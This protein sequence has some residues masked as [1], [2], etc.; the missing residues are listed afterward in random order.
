[1]AGLEGCD[2]PY[3]TARTENT[4]NW[5]S[6]ATGF[7]PPPDTGKILERYWKSRSLRGVPAE[8]CRFLYFSGIFPLFRNGHL[9]R[10]TRPAGVP[11]KP[12]RH[13]FG[14]SLTEFRINCEASPCSSSRPSQLSGPQPPHVCP[15]WPRCHWDCLMMVVRYYRV[16]FRSLFGI[17][18]KILRK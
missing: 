5:K 1:M 17:R 18:S 12:R 16:M 14:V 3:P 4:R 8:K 7:R 15:L 11:A 13:I 6:T 9:H 2:V 10:R